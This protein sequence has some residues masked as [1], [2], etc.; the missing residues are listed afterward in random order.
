MGTTVAP[1]RR[2]TM[3]NTHIECNPFIMMTDPE[4]ILQAM[5]RSDRLNGLRR[6]VCRPLDRPLIPK[7]AQPDLLAFD[8]AIDDGD[9]ELGSDNEVSLTLHA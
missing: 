1:D 7:I 5:E 4:V 2:N 9:E 6:R 8:A 3:R